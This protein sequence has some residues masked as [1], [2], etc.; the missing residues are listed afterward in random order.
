[1]TQR[2]GAP[3]KGVKY[4]VWAWHTQ[5][6]KHAKPDLRRERWG[7]GPGDEDYTCM[8]LEIPDD[9]VLLSDFD[10]WITVLNNYFITDSE[11]EYNDL[12]AQYTQMSEQERRHFLSENWE[13][14]FDVSYLDNDWT[15]RGDWIQA[16][17]WVLKKEYIRKVQFFRTARRKTT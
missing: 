15:K 14:V 6:S 8:E 4:P 11:E 10:S 1:M 5:N 16:T 17:F 13:R 12:E 2:L 7:C 9:E 3:P